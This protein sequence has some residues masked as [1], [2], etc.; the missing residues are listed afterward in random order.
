[1]AF[2]IALTQGIKTG[3]KNLFAEPRPFITALTTESNFTTEQFY[4]CSKIRGQ[5]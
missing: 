2:S 3:L 5:K 4:N 1:M